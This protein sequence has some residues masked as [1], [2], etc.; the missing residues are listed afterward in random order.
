MTIDGKMSR[1]MDAKSHIWCIIRRM[2]ETM[3]YALWNNKGGVGKT[4]LTFILAT[5]YARKNED[6][7]V[8]VI[9]MCPQANVS[10]I[11]LGGNG[12]GTKILADMIKNRATI[13]GYFD[14]RISSPHGKTGG[15]TDMLTS[16]SAHNG[17]IPKNLSLVAGDPLLELQ[18]RTVN[19][20]AVQDLPRESWRN[21]HSWVVDLQEAAQSKHADRK[22]MF[23]LD[24]NPS[25]A[26]Y[27][28]QAIVAAD[29]IIVPCS[30]DGSSARAIRNVCHLVYG[31]DVPEAYRDASFAGK[32][33]QHNLSLP[34]FYLTVLNRSTQYDK[35]PSKAFNAM[36][37]QIKNEV[38][39]VYDSHK[40]DYF[41]G[42]EY[43][44]M[45]S[46]MPDAHT[47]AVVCSSLG[48]PLHQAE[49]KQY[50]LPNGQKTMINQEPL[51]RYKDAIDG[52]V[53]TL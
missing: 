30:P 48:M 41:T 25:F 47:V 4:F 9:D 49:V 45:F 3:K 32:A 20:I 36:L 44:D 7:H 10:E 28:A 1:S 2:G 14:K 6:A 50:P 43:D 51:D 21:V 17:Q 42:R 22:V 46:Y 24:C 35:K 23:F 53:A 31:H 26:A 38:A 33:K 39:A 27:T 37:S 15:E 12:K 40:H 18:V 19:N 11:L 34:V 5:E 8:V 16:V 29:R 13:G 52:I